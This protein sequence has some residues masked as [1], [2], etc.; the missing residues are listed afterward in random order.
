MRLCPEPA[1]PAEETDVE[2]AVSFEDHRAKFTADLKAR[3][4][5]TATDSDPN[6][7]QQ[8]S[9][10]LLLTGADTLHAMTR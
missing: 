8:A 4:E 10:P 5:A 7:R 1:A 6:R 9:I 3:D 2:H